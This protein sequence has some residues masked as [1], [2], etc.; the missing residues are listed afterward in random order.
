MADTSVEALDAL[1]RAQKAAFAADCYPSLETRL[2]R[3]RRLEAAMVGARRRLHA[4]VSVDFG[5]H[6]PIV[7]DLFE[8][9]GVLGR[10]RYI[11][12]QL[13]AWM[14]DSS[15]PLSP[16]VHGSSSAKVIRQPKGVNGVLGPWNFPVESALVMVNDILAAGNRA[17]V[18]ASELAPATGEVLEE[19]IAAAFDPTELAVVNGD[20]QFARHFVSLPWDH[21]TY[22]GGGRAAREI[23]AAAAANLTPVTLELGGKN[24][25]LFLNDGID[26]ALVE[27][28]LYFRIF[29]GGQV[30][31]SPDYALVPRARMAEWISLAQAQWRQMYPAYVGHPDA[32]GTINDRH[33]AR[34]LSYLDEAKSQGATVLSLNGDAPNPAARQIPLYAVIDPPSGTSVMQDEIFG[35]VIAVRPYDSLEQAIAYI[36]AGDRP[37]AAYVVGRNKA[38]LEV[39][40]RTVLSGGVGINV[41]G[42]QGADPNLPFGGVGASGMGCHGGFEGFLNYS[43]SKSVFDCADDNPL[44]IALKAPYGDFAQAFADA[45]FPEPGATPPPAVP[46]TPPHGPPSAFDWTPAPEFGGSEAVIYRSPDGKRVAAAFREKGQF[47][48]QYPFDEFLVVTSGHGTF[49]VEGGPTIQLKTGDVAYFR[50]GTVMHLDLSEDFSDVVMLMSD[51]PVAWR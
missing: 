6:H 13:A 31:T 9:G 22:T 24:P 15:R 14:A 3:L 10:N 28:Y 5:S 33:Y 37:L 8:T 34:I 18:K 39:F 50:E 48:F 35:P 40:S 21:L 25:T 11:Q 44:M 29:K 23:M 41:F 36:N 27:R 42:F 46:E 51:K 26:P 45:V 20:V 17:I 1:F 12:S 49:R 43:H 4:S 32:T 47:T 7:T 16:E 19:V 38:E 30:C 2:D